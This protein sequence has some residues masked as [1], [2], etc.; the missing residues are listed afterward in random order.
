MRQQNRSSP[1]FARVSPGC[2][3]YQHDPGMRL[4]PSS[5]VHSA[6]FAVPLLG[7]LREALANSRTPP[8]CETAPNQL[9]CIR[10]HTALRRGETT[11][12]RQPAQNRA[13]S[14]VTLGD[15]RPVG[16]SARVPAVMGA[17]PGRLLDRGSRT[18][19]ALCA[20]RQEF[21]D[22]HQRGAP[23]H[24]SATMAPFWAWRR[25]STRS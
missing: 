1:G 15:Q 14:R 9:I 16:A 7:S 12:I 24:C 10:D 19:W 17:I 8:I 21:I 13:K 25:G 11:P 4:V 5:R 6:Q 22:D 23:D 20:R 3:R 18:E 2:W